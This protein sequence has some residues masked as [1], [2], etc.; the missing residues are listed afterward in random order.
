MLK[1]TRGPA[2]VSAR[3]KHVVLPAPSRWHWTMRDHLKADTTMLMHSLPSVGR[4]T[5]SP[6]LV[7]ALALGLLSLPDRAAGQDTTRTSGASRDTAASGVSCEGMIGRG[8]E[9]RRRP[10]GA[11]RSAPSWSRGIVKQLIQHR[12]TREAAITPFLRLRT[13]SVCSNFE[14]QESARLLRAQPYIADARVRAIPDGSGGVTLDVETDDEVPVV[15]DGSLSGGTP[16]RIRYGSTNVLG[17]G[18]YAH[19]Q[20]EDGDAFR[21][22]WGARV[23]HFHAFGRPFTASMTAARNPLGE[24]LALS[25][26]QPWL[27]RFQRY[28]FHTEARHVIR[29]PEFL[30]PSG[31]PLTIPV[32]QRF[33][34]AGAVRR[35]GPEARGTFGGFLL[36]Y[37]RTD[38]G[39]EG[40]VVTDDGLEPS[41]DPI[42]D[43]RYVG[44]EATRLGPVIGARMLSYVQ[45]RGLDALEGTQDLA[46]GLQ[47]SLFGGLGLGSGSENLLAADLYA[48]MGNARSFVGTRMNWQ[49]TRE[50]EWRNIVSSGR[51]AWYFKA[52]DD[53]TLITSLEFAAAWRDDVPYQ[54]LLRSRWLLPGFRSFLGTG[55]AAFAEAGRLWQGAVPFG[56]S[57]SRASAG[58]SLLAAI[59]RDSRRLLRADIAFPFVRGDGAKSYE[60]RFQY[61]RPLR[62]FW[63]TPSDLERARAASPASRIFEWP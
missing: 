14:V 53:R 28:A 41:D 21:D 2:R 12:T 6:A 35:I 63:E 4:A 46:R 17:H 32:K 60:L 39:A 23:S 29:Y 24:E 3:N 36:T 61:T 52:S 16:T 58:V 47:V 20:W 5:S 31:D 37:E 13:G 26:G 56:Q 11:V 22:G 43:D 50:D 62:G 30:R 10:P 15:I 8:I 45:A 27:T 25:L 49:A 48:G 42:L 1:F 33:M 51:T 40:R 44:Q 18:V 55:V 34:S 54:L 38:P 7:I 19:L 59:P 9:I 57:V